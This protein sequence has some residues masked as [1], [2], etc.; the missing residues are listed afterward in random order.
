MIKP[1]CNPGSRV[2][3]RANIKLSKEQD[4]ELNIS[5]SIVSETTSLHGALT[6]SRNDVRIVELFAGA[7]GMGIGF[8]MAGEQKKGFII[9]NYAEIILIFL[10][11]LETNYKSF[12]NNSTYRIE[13]CIPS[14]F[15]PI[16]LTKK[17][18]FQLVHEAVKR[19]DGVDMV[20]GG[21]PC[22]GFSQSNR[23]NWDAKNMYNHLVEYF[24]EC[25]LE[26]APKAILL[27]NVQGIL[28]T[29]RYNKSKNKRKFTVVDYIARKFTDAGYVFLPSSRCCL[30]IV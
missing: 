9:I 29:P 30:I 5:S 10:K 3:Y 6:A 26:L 14:D 8:L 2:R 17:Q 18:N 12:Y 7:R 22:Q 28:W 27:E 20:I 16:D 11:S 15:T 4:E 1:A 25:S 23:S 24:I 21:T 13:D 19:V